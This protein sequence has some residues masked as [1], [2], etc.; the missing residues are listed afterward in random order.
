MHKNIAMMM[1]RLVDE[2]PYSFFTCEVFPQKTLSFWKVIINFTNRKNAHSEA[3]V[4][5]LRYIGLVYGE[6][7]DITDN[8]KSV[9]VC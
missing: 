9:E 5:S 1:S 6:G 7:L 2:S 4:Q 8:G 3:L